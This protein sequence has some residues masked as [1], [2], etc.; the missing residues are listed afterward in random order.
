MASKS[1]ITLVLLSVSLALIGG[2]AIRGLLTHA[3]AL[4]SIIAPLFYTNIYGISKSGSEQTGLLT[5]PKTWETMNVDGDVSLL[6]GEDAEIWSFH[7]FG[8]DEGAYHSFDFS[9]DVRICLKT[10]WGD[11]GH[12]AAGMWWTKGFME[13]EKILISD[14]EIRVDFDVYLEKYVYEGTGEWLRVALACAIQRSDS[15]IVYT[16]MDISDSPNTLRHPLGTI[17]LGGDIIYSGGDVVVYRLDETPDKSWKHYSIDLTG[18][19]DRAWEIEEG[20][21]LESVYIVI[22][23]ENNPVDVELRIDNFWISRS[24]NIL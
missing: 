16:E 14:S 17:G 20:D 9:D 6:P 21:L 4:I 19:V 7:P 12:V 15:S 11:A 2:V 18:Y 24:S 5:A 8:L 3:R 10:S 1:N 22:E 13:K 23:V